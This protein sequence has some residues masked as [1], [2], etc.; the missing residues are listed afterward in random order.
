MFSVSMVKGLITFVKISRNEWIKERRLKIS[1]RNVKITVIITPFHGKG[2]TLMVT[3]QSL[4][5]MADMT[6]SFMNGK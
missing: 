3:K 4:I 1:H 5:A 6:H 2:G